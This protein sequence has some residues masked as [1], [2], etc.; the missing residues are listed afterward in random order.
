MGRRLGGIEVGVLDH[1]HRVGSPGD[2]A[3]GGVT[4]RVRPAE[5]LRLPLRLSCRR[6]IRIVWWLHV[7]CFSSRNDGRVAVTAM[8]CAGNDL[9]LA[10]GT[11]HM[12]IAFKVVV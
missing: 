4:L 6:R 5:H 11:V 10:V 2:H 1:H 3:A 9:G 7:G 8:C 12:K